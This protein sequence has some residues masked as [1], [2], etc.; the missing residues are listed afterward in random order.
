MNDSAGKFGIDQLDQA[1]DDEKR[2]MKQAEQAKAFPE[3]LILVE[4]LGRTPL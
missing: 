3:N 4:K 2:R 1:A